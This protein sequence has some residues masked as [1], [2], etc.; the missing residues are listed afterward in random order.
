M[1]TKI[2]DQHGLKVLTRLKESTLLAD[3]YLAGG[4]GLALQLGHRK[5]LDLD[6]FQK[7]TALKISAGSIQSEL[8]GI[9]GPY[10]VIPV[11]R[12]AEQSIWEL[13]G[14]KTTFLAYPFPLLYPLVRGETLYPELEGVVLA[15][16]KEIALMKAYAIGRRPAFRDY[17]DLFYLLEEQHTTIEE[18]VREGQ[19][20]FVLKGEGL[21]NP[22]I[23]LEQLVYT[24]DL[25]DKEVSLEMLDGRKLT[26][27][28]VESH[29]TRLV[30]DFLSRQTGKGGEGT[31]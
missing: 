23:F 13:D 2:L 10:G 28:E 27:T 18:I 17:V 26:P 30:R 9:F 21:F 22:R 8:E 24:E 4:T 16:P 19:R 1:L 3:F 29:L 6:F 15:S 5:S 20:K 25:E 14:I 12:Q 31:Q 7:A 11:A